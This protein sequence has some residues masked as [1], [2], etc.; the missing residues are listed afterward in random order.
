MLFFNNFVF[1]QETI[2]VD[3]YYVEILVRLRNVEK[4]NGSQELIS[5]H[6]ILENDSELMSFCKHIH[7]YGLSKPYVDFFS[8]VD[9][10]KNSSIL[11][12]MKIRGIEYENIYRSKDVAPHLLYEVVD[13]YITFY[14]KKVKVTLLKVYDADVDDAIP[15]SVHEDLNYYHSSLTDK[16]LITEIISERYLTDDEQFKF[17]LKR[18]ST[19]DAIELWQPGVNFQV[20]ILNRGWIWFNIKFKR[21]YWA[22]RYFW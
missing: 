21:G 1:S 3:G 7:N 15:H 19:K 20:F 14:I 13:K 8:I 17:G 10:L 11:R 9:S 12:R 4:R 5:G 22:I 16:Y 6:L 2:I 18:I